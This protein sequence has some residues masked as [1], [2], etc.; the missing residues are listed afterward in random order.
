MD[1]CEPDTILNWLSCIHTAPVINCSQQ[2]VIPLTLVS[3]SAL[4]ASECFTTLSNSSCT[5]RT[6]QVAYIYQF[7]YRPLLRYN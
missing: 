6:Q 1:G 5:V 2:D 3:A 7:G 4:V